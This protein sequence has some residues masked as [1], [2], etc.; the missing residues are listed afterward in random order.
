MVSQFEALGLLAS[1]LVVLSFALHGER[2]IRCVNLVG[3]VL[4]VIYGALVGAW[5]TAIC[6]AVLSGIQIWHIWRGDG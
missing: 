5:S 4:F 1:V 2:R 6:N 3:A